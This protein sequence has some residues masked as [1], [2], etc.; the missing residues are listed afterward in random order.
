MRG[1]GDHRGQQ[2]VLAGLLGVSALL[3]VTSSPGTSHPAGPGQE[4]SDKIGLVLT[5]W[6][7]ALHETPEKSECPAG[8]QKGEAEQF[9]AEPDHLTQLKNFGGFQNRGRNGE[10][11]NHTPMA[12]EDALP[13][14]ELKTTVGYGLNLDGTADGQA[15]SKSCK[16][17]KF[18]SREGERV[19]NQMARVVACVMGWRTTGFMAEFYSDEVETSP[20]NRHLIEITS[21]DDA[22][23]DPSVEVALYK[24]RDRLVRS[25]SGNFIPFISHRVDERFPQYVFKTRGKIVDGVLMSDP[26][27]LARLPLNIVQI[28]GERRIR[29]LRL[30]LKLTETGAD[31][32]L[33]GYEDVDAWWAMHSKG[34]GVGSDIGAFSPAGLYRAARRY[35]DGFPDAATGECTAISVTYKV[36]AVRALIIHSGSRSAVAK[37]Q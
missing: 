26:I 11:A 12:V 1:R 23:N 4:P 28:P 34:P 33:A 31:G 35:A 19:D 15:T 8:L 17:E 22:T 29:D 36:T 10:N 3:S 20:I 16:H 5:D 37:R 9:K 18:T 30:R 6:R 32:V 21:V 13:F 27:P 7:F 24:G 2:H 14:S 25:A